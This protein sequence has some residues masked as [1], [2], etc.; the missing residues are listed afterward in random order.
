MVEEKAAWVLPTSHKHLH[1]RLVGTCVFLLLLLL[2]LLAVG[3]ALR[4]PV[5][6]IPPQQR[7]HVNQMIS[8]PATA[9]SPAEVQTC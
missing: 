7:K 9:I 1:V 8:A 2:L 6:A 3:G 5:K 4:D